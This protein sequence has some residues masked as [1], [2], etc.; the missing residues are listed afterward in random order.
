MMR[1]S[2][3]CLGRL[4]TRSTLAALLTGAALATLPAG[5]GAEQAPPEPSTFPNGFP[6][7]AEFF[8][9]GVWLQHPRN[10]AAFSTMGINTYVGLWREPSQEDLAQLEQYG[11][12]LVIEQ[13]PGLLSLPGAHIIRAW[14]HSDEP[15]NAQSDGHGGYGDCILP[16]Q[17]VERYR[18]MH[19][20]D[21]TRPVFLN[22]GQAVANPKWFGRGAKCSLITPEAY[23]RPASH[24][25]DIVS[26]DIYPAAEER[27]KHVMGKLDLVGRGV[28]NL[29][30]WAQPGQPVWAAIETTHINHPSRR[31]LPE[32]VKSEVW[33]A[34]IQR[35]QRDLLFRARVEAELPRGR[36]L[37]L[38]R[39]RTR[40]HLHQRADPQAG[41]GAQLPLAARPGKG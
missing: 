23:Y 5:V 1:R 17:V 12:N 22:F 35:R 8:P 18:K 4:L 20:V 15:D 30:Q 3:P 31:P 37:P 29:K 39:H 9:V 36:H 33:M 28:A 7:D 27:Q 19:A 14:L 26:F 11:Q 32:E 40:G 38:S 24:G 6:T 34:L 16:Q 41:A 21:T 2:P 25:A 13:S 10:A